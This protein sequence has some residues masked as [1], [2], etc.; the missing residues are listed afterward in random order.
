MKGLFVKDFCLLKKQIAY[1]AIIF[2]IAI[3]NLFLTNSSIFCITFISTVGYIFS[4]NTISYDEYNN[5]YPFLFTL[6]ISKKEYVQEKYIFSLT[7]SACFLFIS[8]ILCIL[9]QPIIPIQWDE[10]RLFLP[11]LLTMMIVY[12][13]IMLPIKL[14]FDTQKS[15]ICIFIFFGT[16]MILSYLLINFIPDSLITLL[17]AL[18]NIPLFCFPIIS[19]PFLYTSYRISQRIVE[20]KNL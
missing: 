7:I 8:L 16:F 2:F 11:I 13:T 5:G 9:F 4:L 14:T 19:L 20:T 15:Q 17:C 3:V 6:P 18:K 1:L 12:T 10:L